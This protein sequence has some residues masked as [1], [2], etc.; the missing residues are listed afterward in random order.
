MN[1]IPLKPKLYSHFGNHKISRYPWCLSDLSVSELQLIPLRR[2]GLDMTSLDVRLCLSMCPVS[3]RT[4]S[5]SPYVGST[6]VIFFG[7]H[8]E[9]T[10][11]VLS[12]FPDVSTPLTLNPC[13]SGL[14]VYVILFYI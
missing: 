5:N 4:Q 8:P 10:L 11:G 14:S 12:R 9:V 6:A 2:L 7:F 1:Y 13:L 3:V